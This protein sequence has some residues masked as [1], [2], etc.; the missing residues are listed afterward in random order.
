[1]MHHYFELTI[2]QLIALNDEDF[3]ELCSRCLDESLMEERRQ[4]VDRQ[5]RAYAR[6]FLGVEMGDDLG[7]LVDW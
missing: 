6:R 5:A 4:Q 2:E 7:A 3:L 1:M